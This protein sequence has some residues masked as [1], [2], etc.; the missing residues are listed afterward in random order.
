MTPFFR[1]IIMFGVISIGSYWYITS[2]WALEVYKNDISRIS[3]LIYAV[4][5]YFTF[6]NGLDTYRIWKHKKCDHKKRSD[7]AWF[8]SNYLVSLGFLGTLV[9]FCL[10][11]QIDETLSTR[12]IIRGI[13]VY[14]STAVYTSIIGLVC[15]IAIQVQNYNTDA[16]ID[17]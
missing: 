6:R 11:L 2:G 5:A 16:C 13:R 10:M 7:L 14:G 15:W 8:V 17:E 1:W 12:I 9:G 3:L 4:F